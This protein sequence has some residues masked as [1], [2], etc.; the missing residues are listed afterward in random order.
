MLLQRPAES[1]TSDETAC[2]DVKSV[3]KFRAAT[4]QSGPADGKYSNNG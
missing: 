3:F 2:K 4:L 1:Q